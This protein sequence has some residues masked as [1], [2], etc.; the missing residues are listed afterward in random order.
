MI[1]DK[2]ALGF[3]AA[4][5]VLASAVPGRRPQHALTIFSGVSFGCFN[6]GR[7]GALDRG[8]NDDFGGPATT[9]L[10]CRLSGRMSGFAKLQGVLTGSRRDRYAVEASGET[11]GRPFP[12]DAAAT[13]RE[14]LGPGSTTCR[15]PREESIPARGC[16]KQRDGQTLQSNSRLSTPIPSR[17]GDDRRGA[18][19]AVAR[20]P[21]GTQGFSRFS[22]AKWLNI[23]AVEH[24]PPNIAITTAPLGPLAD[25]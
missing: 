16:P 23:S 22:P 13:T 8:P 25:R 1:V 15:D 7:R 21:P 10:S 18:R 6:G 19:Q 4:P 11:A 5:A 12:M 2:A 24:A 3:V 14:Y 17:E 20:V 9:A